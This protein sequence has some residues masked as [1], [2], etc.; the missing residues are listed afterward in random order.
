M[1][2]CRGDVERGEVRPLWGESIIVAAIGVGSK[3]GATIVLPW[4]SMP[5]RSPKSSMPR[6]TALLARVRATGDWTILAVAVVLGVVMSG[7]A[8]AFILPLRWLDVQPDRLAEGS[9]MLMAVLIA[10]APIAGALLTGLV[11]RLIRADAA[12][13]GVPAIMYAIHRRQSRVPLSLGVAKWLASTF[14]IGSG[15]SAGPEG[16]IVTIGASLGST[17]ARVLRMPSSTAGTLL[18]CAAAAGMASVFNAP[19]AGIFFVLEVLLRDFS[20]RT[21]TPIVIA[22]VISSATTQSVLGATPL[23]GIAPDLFASEDKA[24]A[25]RQMPGYLALG[26]ACGAVSAA[27][28]RGLGASERLFERLHTRAWTRP[29]CGAALLGALGLA[30]VLVSPVGGPHGAGVV[31]IPPFYGTGYG[32]IAALLD[33]R[34]YVDAHGT[35]N[36]IGAGVA[37]LVA[38]LVLKAIA[39]MFTLGSGGSG[40]LFAPGL[41]LGA[42]LGGTVGL[43]AAAS[44]WFPAANPAQY[45]L[46]GMAGMIAATSHAPLTAILIV[47]E[48]TRSYETILPVMLCAVV[49]TIVGRVL[50]PDSVYTAKLATLGVRVG[51]TGDLAL[52]RRLSVADVAL[53]EPV[54]VHRTDSAETLVDLAE[55]TGVGDFV[56]VDAADRYVGMVTGVDL[57]RALIFREALPLMQVDDLTRTDLPTVSLGETLDLVLEKFNHAD[58]HCLAV[59][60]AAQPGRARGVI[61]RSRVLR[62]YQEMLE[63]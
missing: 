31:A 5:S 22:A 62:R 55:R 37:A 33:P 27:F 56:V 10:V 30:F 35:L 23:F 25:L 34:S 38:L 12:G 24:F 1:W 48:I 61:A 18:G 57:R 58:V 3:A 8:M 51:G 50:A 29:A 49:A 17:V 13:Q 43:L 39:T 16:P 2:E 44:G 6:F 26:I 14:T 54:V 36:P 45:A 7:V 9:P 47:Y 63:R 52:L 15:G 19:I 41:L 46:V 40:G 28:I 21:F 59:I 53:L 32:T 4:G 60:D 20:L 42:A 11:G